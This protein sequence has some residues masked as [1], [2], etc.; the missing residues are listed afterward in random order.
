MKMIITCL[1][2]VAAIAASAQEKATVVFIRSTGHY[3]SAAKFK[4]F[5]NKKIVCLINNKRFSTHE[6]DSG[7]I[8]VDA[9][10]SGKEYKGNDE[11][12]IIKA[13]PGKTYYFQLVLK[14]RFT[15]NELFV[16]EI[17]ESSAKISMNDLK[18]EDC[19]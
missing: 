3:G 9:Q 13:E 10:F 16:Q 15:K 8:Q 5:I 6:V 7:D 11:P 2:A 14:T 4:M 18:T 19:F 12:L 17:T 1:L